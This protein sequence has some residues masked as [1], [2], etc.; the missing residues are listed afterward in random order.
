MAPDGA[1]AGVAAIAVR[2]GAAAAVGA[3]AQGAAA[4]AAGLPRR[5]CRLPVYTAPLPGAVLTG[6]TLGSFIAYPWYVPDGFLWDV[7]QV[8]CAGYTAGTI[9]MTKG[10]PAT[11]GGGAIEYLAQF[12]ATAA[13]SPVSFPQKGAPLLDAN[14]VVY[15][16]VTSALT[17]ATAGTGA[18]ISGYMVVVPHSRL[19]DYLS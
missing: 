3:G 19:D 15:F 4:D 2:F 17:L 10:A 8:T 16:T 9:T 6:V 7:T 14:D 1:D 5:A 18:L 11:V 12:P 13:G